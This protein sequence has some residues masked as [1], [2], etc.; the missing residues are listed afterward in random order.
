[1]VR[2]CCIV[3]CAVAWTVL[4]VCCWGVRNTVR[5]W[6]F[7]LLGFSTGGFEGREGGLRWGVCLCKCIEWLQKDCV[8]W[9]V[10]DGGW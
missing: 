2:E 7:L 10:Q 3:S 5:L 6:C 1:M 4:G 8:K 9:N